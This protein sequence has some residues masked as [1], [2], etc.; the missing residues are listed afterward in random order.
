MIDP[1]RSANGM[2]ESAE[3]ERDRALLGVQL[4]RKPLAPQ[5]RRGESAGQEKKKERPPEGPP[6]QECRV[7]PAPNPGV[8]HDGI[9]PRGVGL[10]AGPREARVEREGRLPRYRRKPIRCHE[11]E[12]RWIT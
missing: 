1:Q 7:K 3:R 11:E 4:E 10:R 2:Q 5:S 8:R 12:V 9:Q 6:R